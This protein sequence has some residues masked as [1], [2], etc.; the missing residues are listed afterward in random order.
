MAAR[1][2]PPPPECPS[3]DE[4]ENALLT[5]RLDEAF[6][7]YTAVLAGARAAGDRALEGRC[8]RG[9]GDTARMQE[10]FADAE[11]DYQAAAGAYLVAGGELGWAHTQRSLA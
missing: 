6:H 10:R 1:T 3:A 2:Y 9:L 5:G 11:R 8:L 4:P 7:S